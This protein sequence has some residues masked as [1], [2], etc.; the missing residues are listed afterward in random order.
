[1]AGSIFVFD[2]KRASTDCVSVCVFA[3]VK[4]VPTDAN[5]NCA[6]GGASR[7]TFSKGGGTDT[8]AGIGTSGGGTKTGSGFGEGGGSGCGGGTGSGG[9]GARTG[10]GGVGGGAGGEG[11]LTDNGRI[12]WGVGFEKTCG[13]RAAIGFGGAGGEDNCFVDAFSGSGSLVADVGGE[14]GSLF[15]EVSGAPKGARSG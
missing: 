11:S 1:M 5:G 10:A 8:G 13:G 14:I 6:G 12:G 9:R 3:L 7:T 4:S 15:F 2:L